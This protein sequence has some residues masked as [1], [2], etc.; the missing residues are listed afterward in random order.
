MAALTQTAF[1]GTALRAATPAARAQRPRIVA[2]KA[3]AERPLWYPGGKAPA[4]LDGSLPGDYGF[5]PLSL[6]SDKELLRWF[7]QAELVHCRTAMT[8]AAGILIPG[9]LTKAGV[10]NVPAWYD[11]GKVWINEHPGFPFES[12]L[13]VQLLLTGWAESKRWADY[14]NPG[15]QGDG[16]FLGVT[17]GFKGQSNGYP[18]GLFDPF[19]FSKG[20]EESLK[21]YKIKE[22]KNGRLAMLALLGFAFQYVATGTDP[23]T[24]LT[25]HLADPFHVTF[26]TNG[27]SLPFVGRQ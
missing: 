13:F 8:A 17:D 23:I 12:L 3:A 14:K 25:D 7:Q 22:V 21:Q 4:H 11:A 16:S 15:S 18:G 1:N 5:D 27:V 2:V 26:A 19:G 24:N 20:S 6:G 10:L 9:I